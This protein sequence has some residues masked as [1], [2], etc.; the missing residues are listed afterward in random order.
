MTNDNKSGT[1]LPLIDEEATILIE[2]TAYHNWLDRGRYSQPG[3]ELDDWL[4][5]ENQVRNG[6]R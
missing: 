2:E 4:K 1:L 5:A 3:N 6:G